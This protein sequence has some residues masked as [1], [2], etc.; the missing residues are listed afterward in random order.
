VVEH[1]YLGGDDLELSNSLDAPERAV[2]KRGTGAQL[3]AHTLEVALAPI[4]WTMLHL[5]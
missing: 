4:S 1:V 2:P 3:D 5:R